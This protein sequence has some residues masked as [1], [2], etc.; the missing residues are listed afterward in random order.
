LIIILRKDVN[1]I[2]IEEYFNILSKELEV[3]KLEALNDNK[4]HSEKA[5]EYKQ[6]LEIIQE[7]ILA[8]NEAKELYRLRL[9]K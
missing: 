1:I 8:L 6:E 3:K 5:I 4:W 7:R 2:K 9:V